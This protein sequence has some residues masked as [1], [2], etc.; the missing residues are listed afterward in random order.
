MSIFFKFFFSS[1]FNQNTLLEF[2]FSCVDFGIEKW[3][4]LG[5]VFYAINFS[6]FCTF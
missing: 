4:T 3:L 2:F 5:K 6:F 1:F